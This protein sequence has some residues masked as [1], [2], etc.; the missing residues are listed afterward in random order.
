MA[1][2]TVFSLF[3]FAFLAWGCGDNPDAK[4]PHDVHGEVGASA[5]AN[6]GTNDAPPPAPQPTPAPTGTGEEPTLVRLYAWTCGGEQVIEPGDTV[7]MPAGSL[8]TINPALPDLGAVTVKDGP[9]K[10]VKM[11]PGVALELTATEV[12]KV[13]DAAAQLQY[14]GA[15]LPPYPFKVRLVRCG[16]VAAAD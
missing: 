13:F 8:V 15:D 1:R 12:G 11:D 2:F 4:S 6:A 3:F 9:F 5:S 7:E 14:P 16:K 10:T